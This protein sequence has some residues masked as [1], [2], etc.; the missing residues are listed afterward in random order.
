MSTTYLEKLGTLY[1][2]YG[3]E[4]RGQRLK[5]FGKIADLI[6]SPLL[7]ATEER[8]YEEDCTLK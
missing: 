8:E 2:Y 3:R 5:Q 1:M 6:E 7:L 4:K